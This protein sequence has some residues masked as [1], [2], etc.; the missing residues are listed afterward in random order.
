MYLKKKKKSLGLR[1]K[2][3]CKTVKE[4]SFKPLIILFSKK[5][6]LTFSF[7]ILCPIIHTCP[8]RKKKLINSK[9]KLKINIPDK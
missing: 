4:M 6:K 1:I 2:T 5:L 3:K 8:D 7:K 9:Y